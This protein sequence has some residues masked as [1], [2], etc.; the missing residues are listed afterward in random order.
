[1]LHVYKS[2]ASLGS[3]LNNSVVKTI[4]HNCL[5][6]RMQEGFVGDLARKRES[7]AIRRVS[8]QVCAR[9]RVRA[10]AR[11]GVC[12]SEHAGVRACERARLPAGGRAGARVRVCVCA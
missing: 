8:L 3:I 11:A 7:C 2:E 12:A 6:R 1:M 9:V 10:S 4:G 5:G